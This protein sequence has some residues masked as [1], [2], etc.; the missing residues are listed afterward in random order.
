MAIKSEPRR[1][2]RPSSEGREQT[3]RFYCLEGTPAAALGHVD[4]P[5]EETA[6]RKAINAF[7]IGT[8]TK[9]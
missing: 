9:Y 5:D 3:K 1:G 4:A 2:T 6:I 7:A 8:A